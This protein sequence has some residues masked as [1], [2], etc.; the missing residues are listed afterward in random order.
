V[1]AKD[2]A[3][4]PACPQSQALPTEFE[5][6]MVEHVQAVGQAREEWKKA[7]TPVV[8]M[9]QERNALCACG[10]GRKYKKCCHIKP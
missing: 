4:E 1:K 7:H 9:K 2:E 3:G 5:V 6:L 10:S 8:S